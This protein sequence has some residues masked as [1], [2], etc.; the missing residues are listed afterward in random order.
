MTRLIAAL[1]VTLSMTALAD[2][3]TKSVAG[4]WKSEGAEDMGNGA[5]ATREFTLT[6]KT[7]DLVFTI[8][9]DKE[10]KTPLVA[11]NF[12]GPWKETGDSKG[13]PGAHEATFEFAKK[14]I[15]LKAKDAAKGFGMDQCGL[16]VGKA[17]DVSKTGCS[18]V[19]SVAN[20]GKEFD[21]IKRDGDK[22]FF[23]ARPADNNMGTED[24][25]PTS[26]GA[27]LAKAK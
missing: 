14:T 19:G 1:A 26:L 13:V 15:T 23:G 4:K 2:D 11:M 7:W 20:Y 16:E 12:S 8:W 22:L 10:L 21:L 27:A 5:F 25:R 9:A 6:G 3:V 17:K 24:K 18:F